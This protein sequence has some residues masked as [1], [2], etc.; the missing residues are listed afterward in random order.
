MPFSIWDFGCCHWQAAKDGRAG[1]PAAGERER[2]SLVAGAGH[3]GDETSQVSAAFALLPT[4]RG[5]VARATHCCS[6]LT[7]LL[8]LRVVQIARTLSAG[9][10]TMLRAAPR[11]DKPRG[12][13]IITNYGNPAELASPSPP[14]ALPTAEPTNKN[15]GH[16]GFFSFLYLKKIKISKIYGGFEKF[17]NYTPVA[18]C[19][20]DR[21]PV[22]L[23]LGDRT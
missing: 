18:P 11:A 5:E 8:V 16:A 15:R 4:C 23:W 7:A 19:L 2:S 9:N 14:S 12:P 3:R 22:A 10:P 13:R 1:G 21:G 20:D 17:Q 6:L